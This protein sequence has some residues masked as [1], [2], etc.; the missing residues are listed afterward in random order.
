MERKFQGAKRPGNESSRERKGPGAK[1]PGRELARVLLELSLRGANWPGSEKAVNPPHG[2]GINV[3]G[4]VLE[5]VIIAAAAC[6]VLNFMEN[7]NEN[8]VCKN[9]GHFANGTLR[10]LDSS[11]TVWSFRLLDN[12]PTGHFAYKTFHLHDIS[13]TGHFADWTVRLIFGHFAYK[14]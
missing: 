10:L 1:V 8:V 7:E 13:P 11:S 14:F 5:V 3:A 12:S 2:H 6:C 9:Y 4:W